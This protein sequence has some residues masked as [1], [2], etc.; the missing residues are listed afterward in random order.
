MANTG[1]GATITADAI[2]DFFSLKPKT[3]VKKP[4]SCK[5]LPDNKAKTAEQRRSSDSRDMYSLMSE[6]N[7][8]I[9]DQ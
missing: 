2:N 7:G 5:Q 6:P 4:P 3:L 8:N 1:L 9:F